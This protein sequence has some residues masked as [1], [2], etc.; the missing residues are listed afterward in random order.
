MKKRQTIFSLL[1]YKIL[2]KIVK[3]QFPG[4]DIN[5]LIEN[6]MGYTRLRLCIS[7]H[8][9]G[10]HETFIEKSLH[11]VWDENNVY[12]FNNP[13]AVVYTQSDTMINA[14]QNDVS[15][16]CYGIQSTGL[17]GIINI[18][19]HPLFIYNTELFKLMFNRLI[20]HNRFVSTTTE[21]YFIEY[22]KR[23]HH[24]PLFKRFA[25]HSVDNPTSAEEFAIQCD[26]KSI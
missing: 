13:G 3:T 24:N 4:H 11:N 19:R 9:T 25:F 10:K 14:G 16:Y 20:V 6:S 21:V 15:I 2:D 5:M 7:K 12:I 17:S 18:H 22:S 26:L 1:E 23:S 8:Y